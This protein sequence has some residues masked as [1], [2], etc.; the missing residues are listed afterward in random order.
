MLSLGLG[1]LPAAPFDAAAAS[2][3]FVLRPL[4]SLV[5][6]IDELAE[7]YSDFPRPCHLAVVG[8]G[9]S[10]C[11]LALA[12]H[13]RL[14]RH[15]SFRLTLLQGNDRLLPQHPRK[16]AQAF[17]QLLHERG[18]QVRLNAS[19]VAAEQGTLHLDNG[20]RI[21]CDAVLWATNAAPPPLLRASG[22]TLDKAGFLVVQD[23]LQWYPIRRCSARA[24][25]CRFRPYPELPKNGV[26][27][28]RE[29]AVLFDNARLLHERPLRPF[30]RSASR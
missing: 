2:C 3:S 27:A 28:V 4:S 20:E 7:H 19:V 6:K 30:A 14:A 8:G 12:L 17:E 25:V 5:R 21:A 10:G 18:I 16:A 13:H 15:A 1:S 26:H 24:I 9:A 11:E 23:T 22:L 29:G